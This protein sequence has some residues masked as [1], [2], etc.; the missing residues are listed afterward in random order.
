M[1]AIAEA[2]PQDR[3]QSQH[4]MEA[5]HQLAPVGSSSSQHAQHGIESRA[6]PWSCLSYGQ[7]QSQVPLAQ[8]QEHETLWMM[9]FLREEQ[10]KERMAQAQAQAA[11]AQAQARQAQAQ[12]QAQAQQAQ[13]HQMAASGMVPIP[14]VNMPSQKQMIPMAGAHHTGGAPFGMLAQAGGMTPVGRHVALVGGN[15]APTG[16]AATGPILMSPQQAPMSRGMTPAPSATLQAPQHQHQQ[17]VSMPQVTPLQQTSVPVASVQPQQSP[18]MQPPPGSGGGQVPQ[19]VGSSSGL[20]PTPLAVAQ[21]SGGSA[22]QL[23]AASK[24]LPM[25]VLVE[26][27]KQHPH[28]KSRITEIVSRTDFSEAQ[29]MSAIQQ[30]VREAGS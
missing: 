26:V 4:D 17:H 24:G 1:P 2:R 12:A 23:G 22:S 6:S 20:M 8:E 14:G 13:A 3:F 21:G 16:G 11:Q 19:A 5:G 29:K 28:L 25:S 10:E 15:M 27:I 18:A 7:P 9:K 30:I